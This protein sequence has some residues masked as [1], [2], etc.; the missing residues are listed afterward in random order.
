MMITHEPDI[1]HHSERIIMI[2]DGKLFSDQMNGRSR[3]I[4]II[5]VII[6]DAKIV[7]CLC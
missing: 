4:I 5:F 2:L 3:R 1:A 6:M 7:Y